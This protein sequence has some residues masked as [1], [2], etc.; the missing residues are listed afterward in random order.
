MEC[1]KCNMEM[2]NG[3]AGKQYP[4]HPRFIPDNHKLIIKD[5]PKLTLFACPECGTVQMKVDPEALK[6]TVRETV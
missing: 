4:F 1:S 6:R 3:I 5:Y 2:I